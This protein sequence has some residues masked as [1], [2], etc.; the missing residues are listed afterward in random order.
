MVRPFVFGERD[1]AVA[2][3]L[4]HGRLKRGRPDFQT[5]FISVSQSGSPLN[6]I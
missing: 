5:S 1:E 3:P 6:V 2:F 4:A